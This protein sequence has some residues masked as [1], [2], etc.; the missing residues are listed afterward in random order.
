MISGRFSST[1]PG[2][3][4]FDWKSRLESAAADLFRMG[5]RGIEL[6]YNSSIFEPYRKNPELLRD[7]LIDTGIK[8]VGITASADLYL[9][10]TIESDV[11]HCARVSDAVATIG[12]EMLLIVPGVRR[13]KR[14]QHALTDGQYQ[15]MADALNEIGKVCRG[16]GIRCCLSPHVRHVIE[17]RHE[18]TR[19]L[20]LTDPTLVG[21]SFDP[22]HTYI[23]GWDPVEC[24]E[25]HGTRIACV[26]LRN[27]RDG[28]YSNPDVGEIDM[29]QVLTA[30]KSS[31]YCGW[32]LPCMPSYAHYGKSEAE[33]AS[34]NFSYLYSN[35]W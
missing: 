27:L 34:D 11:A 17:R 26:H 6:L 9:S 35:L 21:L 18:V 3:I 25:Q 12:G 16:N 4:V 15:C 19:I 30:L 28:R 20:G 33:V 8:P 10:E 29:I 31:G 24:V 1:Q 23:G 7:E 22:S 5:Y 32:I 13:F 2:W 14:P